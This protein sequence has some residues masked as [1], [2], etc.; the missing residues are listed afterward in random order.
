MVM[1]GQCSAAYIILFHI[2]WHTRNNLVE[3]AAE[4]GAVLT[5]FHS[6]EHSERV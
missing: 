1:Y 2:P 4:V 6:L 3:K 5:A